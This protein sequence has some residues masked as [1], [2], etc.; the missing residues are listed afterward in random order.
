MH[1]AKRN[2]DRLRTAGRFADC[3]TERPTDRGFATAGRAPAR[4]VTC[5]CA[6]GLLVTMRTSSSRKVSGTLS[7]AI[8]FRRGSRAPSMRTP[9]RYTSRSS[10]V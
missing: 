1:A 4:A 2:Y 5:G 9:A 10:V 8:C 7:A 6:T 3:A